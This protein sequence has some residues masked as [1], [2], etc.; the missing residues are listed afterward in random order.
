MAATEI[1][2]LADYWQTEAA[3]LDGEDRLECELAVARWRAVQTALNALEGQGLQS[4]TMAGNS[5]TRRDI[6][7]M[8]A[9]ANALRMEIRSYVSGGGSRLIDNRLSQDSFLGGRV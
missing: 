2:A 7:A 9:S 3:T 4:Y 1:A 8:H 5:Y 6:P